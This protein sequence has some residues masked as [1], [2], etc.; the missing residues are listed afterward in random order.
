M[1]GIEESDDY[2]MYK[3]KHGKGPAP[4]LMGAVTL[5]GA[6]VRNAQGE[7]LGVLQEMMVDTASGTVAYVLLSRG[8]FVELGDKLHPVPWRALALD[9]ATG[10]FLLAVS[11]ERLQ[12]APGFDTDHWPDMADERWA[13]SVHAWYGTAPR[14]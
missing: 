7:H 14:P 9:A 1:M 11:K 3:N 2:G 12:D 4:E 10:S 6:H 5:V 13:G 8:R